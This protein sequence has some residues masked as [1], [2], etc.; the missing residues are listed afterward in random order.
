M[1]ELID[2]YFNVRVKL[3]NDSHE[4]WENKAKDFTPFD[5]EVIIYDINKDYP[6]QLLKI[7][8]G[9]H[10]VGELPFINDLTKYYTKVEIDEKI[11]EIY[12]K[13]DENFFTLNTKIDKVEEES[14]VELF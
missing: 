9:V 11:S 6:F 7:G 1:A 4:N 12:T 13:I 3:R 5:G 8:D 10:K 2:K 14:K